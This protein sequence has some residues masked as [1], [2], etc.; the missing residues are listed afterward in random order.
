[1]KQITVL[2]FALLSLVCAGLMFS[3]KKD[4]RAAPNAAKQLTLTAQ[5]NEMVNTPYGLVPKSRVIE[6]DNKTIVKVNN[7]HLQMMDI[8]SGK[9]IKDYGALTKEEMDAR[10]IDPYTYAAQLRSRYGVGQALDAIPFSKPTGTNKSYSGP[11]TSYYPGYYLGDDAISNIK[12]FSTNWVVPNKPLDTVNITTT[13][14]WNGLSGGAIQ[15]VLQ[16]DQGQGP[17]YTIANWYFVAGSYMHGTFVRVNPGTNLQG[18]ITFVSNT[19]DTTW[20]YKESFVGYPTADVTIVRNSE[21]TGLSEDYE[22]YTT[23]LSAWPNQP[24]EAMTNIKLTLRSGTAPDTLHWIGYND[25]PVT[26]PT[27]YNSVVV[28]NSSSSGEVRFYFG[29][30]TSITPDSTYKIAS[31]VGTNKVL[32]VTGGGTANGTLV[33]LYSTNSPTSPNQ[34]WKFVSVGGGYYKILPTNA[35]GKAMDVTGGSS[36]PGTQVEIYTDNGGNAQKWTITSAGGGYYKLSPACAPSL[37][38]E[39]KNNS[40]ANGTKIQINTPGSGSGQKFKFNLN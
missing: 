34:V 25:G 12:T 20:T 23:L 5:D 15:P 36:T 29:D 6:V 9:M 3:C 30:G 35:P 32:D 17:N 10:K 26:T 24:Y 37:V 8:A 40:S 14:L 18:L 33:E 22:P 13:F 38:L 11:G 28:N 16:W 4:Q 7:G 1:M 2:Q 21:A 27:G 39:V 19:N 31:A